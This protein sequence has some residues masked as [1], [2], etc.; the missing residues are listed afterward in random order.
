MEFYLYNNLPDM[1]RETKINKKKNTTETQ[2]NVITFGPKNKK[3][4]F[5]RIGN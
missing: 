3:S 2:T 4:S 1:L 5:T